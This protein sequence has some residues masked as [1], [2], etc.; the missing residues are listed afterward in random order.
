MEKFLIGLIAFIVIIFSVI[1]FAYLISYPFAKIHYS[2]GERVGKVI[3]WSQKG[4]FVKNW[5]GQLA[6]EGMTSDGEG[7]V[8]PYILDFGIP[9][10]NEE[11]R[12][13]IGKMLG[14]EVQIKYDQRLVANPFVGCNEYLIVEIQE[15]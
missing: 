7:G 15:Q 11:I 14:K 13:K 2:D 5:C 8:M 6:L 12:K 10:G 4:I 9:R 1:F 3:K